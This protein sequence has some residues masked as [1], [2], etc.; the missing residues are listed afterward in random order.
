MPSN[1]TYDVFLSHNSQDK[2]RVRKL[3]ERLRDAGLRVWFDEWVIRPGDDIYLAIEHGLEA[4]RVQ[5]LC[6]SP[7]ALG[8][9]WVTLERGTVLFRDPGNAGRRFVPL[10]LADCTMPDTLRRY[11]YVD[12]RG[13]TQAA[14]EELVSACRA[15]AESPRQAL[16]RQE[17]KAKQ[18]ARARP[19]LAVLERTLMGHEEYAR[20]VAVSQDGTWAVSGSQDK[21]V[22]IWNL[23][24]GECRATLKGHT[25]MVGAVAV[26]P[27]GERILSGSNDHSVRVWD[28]RGRGAVAS[29]EAS[30]NYVW[31]VA[32]LPDGR[33]V[34]SS[35]AHGDPTLKIW[36]I[37]SRRC[38]A[39]LEGHT[40]AVTSAVVSRDG[41]RA[42]SGS[43]D[44]TVRLWDL[45][46]GKCLATLH[47]H[48]EYVQSV[49]ITPSGRLAVSGSDDKTVKIW[50]LD[51]GTC[52]GTLEGH[53]GQVFS[54]AISSGGGLIASTGYT[55]RTVR[56][57][58]WKSAACLQVIE[59][60]EAHPHSAA[61]SPD[62]SRLVVS[63]NRGPIFVY[64][65]TAAG[66]A[67]SAEPARRYVNAKVVLL[68]EGTVGKTS[69]A[70][71]LVQDKY[72]VKD[73]THGMNVW[74]LQLPLPP[75]AALDREALLWDLAGQEDYRL[76]HRLFLDE[77]ALALLLINP[78]KDDPFA[79][80]GDWLKAL[81]TAASGQ[82]SRR[83]AARLLIF[84][85][86]DVGGMK[87]GNAKIE[88]FI[89][90]NRFADW[91]ETS[92]KTGENCS[93]QANAG[94]P[95]KLKQLIADSIPWGKL[96]WTGTPRVLAELKNAVMKMRD[97]ADI[98]LL[99]FAEL[100]QRLE[101]AL[102]GEKF[103]ES[104]VRAAVALLAN[105]GLASPL[106]FGD[107]V[108][109]QPELLNGYAGSIIRSARANRDEIGCVLE[110]DIYR[111]DFDFTG[112]DRLPRPDEEL[113]LR[114][115]V[116]TFLDH[117]LCIAEDT[118]Q[119]RHLV[120]PS[121]YRREKDIP[122]EPDVFVS[123][124]FGGEWQTIWTTLVVRL[125]YSQEFEHRELWRNAAQFASSRGHLL[126][127]KIDNRQGEGEA[128]ISLFFDVPTPEELKVIF[129]EY[130]HRHLAH[131]GCEVR[132]DRRYV[133]VACET[134]IT[135][136][137]AVRRRF[138]AGKDFITCQNCDE[139]V[140][141]VDF[142]ELRL[143][144]DPVARKIFKMEETAARQLDAQALEQILF[145]HVQAIAGEANQIFRRVAEY[146]YGI[147]GEIEFKDNDGQPSGKRIYVQ[148]KSGNSYLRT[149]RGDGREVFDVK[150]ER[151][152]SYWVSQPADVYLV[153]RQ[154][155]ERTNEQTI[156]QTEERT[157]EQTIRWMNV[158]RY[159]RN[160]RD[161][162]SR[163][164]VFEGEPLTME[165]VWKVRDELF[166]RPRARKP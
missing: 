81:E 73:R 61:F 124:T 107:L 59:C 157:N 16:E 71:R 143:K 140:Q 40:G 162:R 21:T 122:W 76:I 45:E 113:L 68:G 64:R 95:S 111:P 104:D 4:A 93:D 31:S 37:A 133:C 106:K 141:L 117:S 80:A 2:P 1:F 114:A 135:D 97:A 110:A 28:P 65:I 8:S 58:D 158:T 148:L 101:Q 70:H 154:T 131:Y 43:Y 120:F 82:E 67:L 132:R 30:K 66:A 88:R 74:P 46:T 156:R 52:V 10:L 89:E 121:Q 57:W 84:S 54:V 126:G 125:W 109:L 25:D 20:G 108:L 91:L 119:G 38:L 128:T 136:L 26:M 13:E 35:A 9:E 69:L 41:K 14:F 34:I 161:Q 32:P 103:G 24:T 27:D 36:D 139:R 77:T 29:W 115:M 17:P 50:D 165:A 47:G 19:D 11:K 149:R 152:L 87:V 42:V 83:E 48:S 78:Q 138:A 166:P 146:D 79:E 144:S 163:Q 51:A 127:L 63:T 23:E 55:D 92:A 96:P 49:Q 160:R 44:G 15:E 129:I 56:L 134:P 142:I 118:P 6:L 7:A 159:L 86:I 12:Y 33:R 147:D 123:Y 164:I 130:V 102:P 53:Q 150:N 62:G 112:V 98:R 137:A 155:E 72:V 39:T 116:Q 99:R 145:G 100:A 105:H 85:Q 3:A 151:H 94:K 60:G 90:Q 22:K 153:I 5:V 75:D 18:K